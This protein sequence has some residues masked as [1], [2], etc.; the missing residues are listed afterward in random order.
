MFFKISFCCNWCSD[1]EREL[2]D[3]CW[4][5][6]RE[7]EWWWWF[8]FWFWFWLYSF[9]LLQTTFF[10]FFSHSSV[11]YLHITDNL[12]PVNNLVL[13]WSQDKYMY[14]IS[15]YFLVII[16]VQSYLVDGL[17]E[18]LMLICSDYIHFAHLHVSTEQALIV[19]V[20]YILN[21]SLNSFNLISSFPSSIL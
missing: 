10:L 7:W 9:G 17:S 1:H 3:C 6:L 18:D 5:N 21:Y 12:E 14:L 20:G 2:S 8:S 15:H 4:K 16:S 13:K 11:V 19:V